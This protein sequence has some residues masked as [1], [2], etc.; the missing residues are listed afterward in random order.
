LVAHEASNI[1]VWGGM[2]ENS[3]LASQKET[4]FII[5]FL[6]LSLGLFEL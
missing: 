5:K 2:Q 6:N 3:L 1:Y 4:K